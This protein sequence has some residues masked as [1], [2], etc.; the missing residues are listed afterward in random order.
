MTSVLANQL[1]QLQERNRLLTGVKAGS[2]KRPS[3]LFDEKEAADFDAEAIYSLGMGGFQELCQDDKTLRSFEETFFSPQLV[4]QDL[5][6]LTKKE[7][8]SY[9]GPMRRFL[10]VISPHFEKKSAHKV[11][12][13]MV[14]KW[15]V[16]EVYVDDLMISI[17][18]YHDTDMFVRMVQIVYFT[19]TSRWGFLF[20]KVKQGGS[21]LN[22]TLLA[23]RCLVDPTLL[24]RIT[25]GYFE[26]HKHI[27][28]YPDYPFAGPYISFVTLMNME[29][30]MN[31]TKLD[32]TQVIHFY[33]RLE[34]LIKDDKVP[35]ALIG[36]MMIFLA[37]C[38]KAS[39]TEVAVT[40]FLRKIVSNATSPT[41]RNVILTYVRVLEACYISSIEIKDAEKLVSL[42][43]FATHFDSISKAFNV[44]S[45]TKILCESLKS[46][47]ANS[48]TI[49][50]LE[51]RL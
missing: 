40:H 30:I 20:D 34:L 42:P 4:E 28:A 46:D 14:R 1:K 9:D 11:L 26:L 44:R 32:D 16:N 7:L 5:T 25:K 23:Q 19:K 50:Q 48:S 8:Q 49:L 41:I 29:T 39:L 2:I 10:M 13:W 43:N 33:Q 21:R 12:E 24:S 36:A 37:L 38:E 6:L 22:R 18:P 35:D 31:A 45:F 3:F 17:L 27:I 47:P 51:S 15:R